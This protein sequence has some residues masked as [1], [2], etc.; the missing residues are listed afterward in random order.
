VSGLLAGKRGLIFGLA[1]KHSIAYGIAQQAVAAGAQVGLS[2]LNERMARR[3]LPLAEA[4]GA[5]MVAPCDVSQDAELDAFFQQAAEVFEGRIDFVV[6]SLAFAR[7]EELQGRFTETSREGFGQALD[8][9]VF[10]LVALA[11][12]AAPLL[13]GGGSL[14][15][16]S[17]YGA[18]KV[19]P[20]Y[21]VM[22]PAKAAL[23][24]SVRYLANDLG[25]DGVRVNAISA[26]PIKTLAA[27]GIPGFRTMLRATEQIVP[28][29]RNVSQTE[30]G[31]A[32][33]FLLSD[34][35]RGI[36]GEVLHVDAGYH[37]L[38]H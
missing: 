30:V 29:R 10:S 6:H 31:D 36:T 23:E 27:A 4:L 2:Y 17:Y 9:S 20:N 7:R 25:P 12:H 19:V 28:L 11:R 14:L 35:A 15:T 1:N 13:S 18:E 21:N 26:G 8:I 37:V 32:A 16:M 5:A 38:G 34:M 24:A 3:A 33:V 22:G